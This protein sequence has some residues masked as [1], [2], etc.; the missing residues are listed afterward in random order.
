MKDIKDLER[1]ALVLRQL[2]ASDAGDILAEILDDIRNAAVTEMLSSEKTE[3]Q[4]HYERGRAAAI[5]DVI[6][7][8]RLV[9][10]VQRRRERVQEERQKDRDLLK[11]SH[12]HRFPV[13]PGMV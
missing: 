4:L 2:C 11:G 9:D 3:Q 12:W 8:L 13:Q 10:S 5:L 1:R 7:R 6:H